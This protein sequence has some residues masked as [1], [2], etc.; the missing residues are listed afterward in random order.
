MVAL[1]VQ[2]VW[3]AISD[4]PQAFY[5]LFEPI[6]DPTYLPLMFG[7]GYVTHKPVQLPIA[8]LRPF[9]DKTS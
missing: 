3:P 5:D 1:E 8:L 6:T 4:D 2:P 7:G 9:S